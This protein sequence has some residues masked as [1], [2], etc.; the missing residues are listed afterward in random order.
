MDSCA[1]SSSVKHVGVAL[2]RVPGGIDAQSSGFGRAAAVLNQGVRINA[3]GGSLELTG[4]SLYLGAV[5]CICAS[6]GKVLL[7]SEG[8]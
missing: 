2:Q 3:A 5:N 8:V 7:V 4:G 1:Q 6:G